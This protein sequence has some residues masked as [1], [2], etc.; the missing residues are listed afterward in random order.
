MAASSSGPTAIRL[1]GTAARD[2]P[3]VGLLVRSFL[4]GWAAGARS[5]LGPGAPTV[6]GG[7]GPA[8]RIGAAAAIVGELIADK[9][10]IAPSRLAFGGD[11][12][13]AASGAIGASMLAGRADAQRLLPV[14]AGAVGGFVAAHA[15]ASWRA[16]AAGRMPD[17][18][19]AL[20][21]DAVA[22]AAAASACLPGRR[23][24]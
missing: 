22:L 11:R 1:D 17:L 23:S 9:L 2:R 3:G 12:L 21:E 4:L 13:R 14:L 24:A 6:T 8:V 10:P 19:A 5:S 16:W 18:R 7:G 20:L 15:G